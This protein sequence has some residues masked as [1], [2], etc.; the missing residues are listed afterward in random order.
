MSE[1]PPS[2]C[3]EPR[4]AKARP[5]VPFPR[6]IGEA[7]R[8]FTGD[9]ASAHPLVQFAK[10]GF[11]G[12]LATIVNAVA[13]FLFAWLVFRCVT[14][15]D[16]VVRL[17]GLSVPP[18]ADEAARAR[19]ANEAAVCAF[20]IAN[21]F[22]YVLNRLFVFVPGKLSVWKEFLSFTAVGALA[23]GVGMGASYLLIRFA[24]AETSIGLLANL[25]ASMAFNYILRKFFIFKG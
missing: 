3:D 6:T 1:Q 14:E 16:P 25:V 11:V 5:A 17:L 4:N 8:Q 10:Y 9:G 20:L 13:V 21:T 15:T 19:L 2:P 12:A 24:G 7:W 22:C 23:L 18:M